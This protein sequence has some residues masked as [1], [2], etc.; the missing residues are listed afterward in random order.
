LETHCVKRF[1]FK[2]NSATTANE[3]PVGVEVRHAM[4]RGALTVGFE[5]LSKEKVLV[6]ALVDGELC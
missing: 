1:C 2:A 5:T 6:V 3:I 4:P